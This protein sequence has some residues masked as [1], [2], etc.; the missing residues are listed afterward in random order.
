MFGDRRNKNL[1]IGIGLLIIGLL[2]GSITKRET[3]AKKAKQY[4]GNTRLATYQLTYEMIK[5]N[6][7][8]GVGYGNFLSAFRSH[9]A[10]R[11]RDE[12]FYGTKKT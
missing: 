9:Y 10:K 5:D 2:A 7:V 1:L 6:P 8:L 12:E 4:S 11:K 3:I